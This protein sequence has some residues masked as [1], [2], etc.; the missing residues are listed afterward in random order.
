VYR[1]FEQSVQIANPRGKSKEIDEEHAVHEPD[2]QGMR[3]TS[4]MRMNIRQ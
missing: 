2:A 3:E 1:Q 4:S